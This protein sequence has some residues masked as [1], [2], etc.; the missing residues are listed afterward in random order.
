MDKLYFLNGPIEGAIVEFLGE[1]ITVGRA[2]DNDICIEDETVSVHH[3]VILRQ[4]G[5]WMVKDLQSMNGTF[6]EGTKIARPAKLRNGN[7]VIFGTV[8]A[9]FEIIAEEAVATPPPP[10]P[11][12]KRTSVE[13]NTSLAT[14]TRP[15]PPP[16]PAALP[17]VPPS[18]LPPV[19]AGAN[20]IAATHDDGVTSSTK[21]NLS[22]PK[23]SKTDIKRATSKIA[24]VIFL[25]ALLLWNPFLATLVFVPLMSL[26]VFSLGS[27]KM[28]NAA[29][30]LW[31]AFAV[32]KTWP[33]KNR[34]RAC[35]H[36]WKR[37]ASA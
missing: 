27:L 34:C 11:R 17:P 30:Y 5:N 22:C 8:E 25:V 23:C 15:T 12:A 18:S 33:R 3:A 14:P 4:D 2:P 19:P 9:R 35:G 32:Y 20:A 13:V 24:F 31:L 26:E 16:P 1:K 37:K 6:I 29:A 36:R 10:P 7:T 28:I 21:R